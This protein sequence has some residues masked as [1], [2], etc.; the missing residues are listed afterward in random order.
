M[1]RESEGDVTGASGMDP[2]QTQKTQPTSYKDIL[3][4]LFK[5]SDNKEKEKH[6]IQKEDYMVDSVKKRLREIKTG[7][8]AISF[9]AKYGIST[10]IKFIHA[11]RA[12]TPKE[13]FRPY[14]LKVRLILSF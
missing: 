9:F 7:E 6:V 10:P 5:E 11:I 8:Q 12:K 14:D 4:N 13:M 2:T 1:E 3:K